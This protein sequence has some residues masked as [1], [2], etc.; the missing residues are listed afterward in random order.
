M[1][2]LVEMSHLCSLLLGMSM[3]VPY[4]RAWSRISI[5]DHVSAPKRKMRLLL[6]I[7]FFVAFLAFGVTNTRALEIS[8]GAQSSCVVLVT[9]KVVCWGVTMLE[10][11]RS[12]TPVE[13]PGITTATSVAAGASR[14]CVLLADGK[15]MCWG[16]NDRG[17]VSYTHLTLPTILLV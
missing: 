10:P 7:V 14:N 16:L 12:F 11:T 1:Q 5:Q 4:W 15:V 9:G 17:P 3:E 13:I 2:K 8:L 6:R